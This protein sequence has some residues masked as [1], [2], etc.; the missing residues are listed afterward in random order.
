[1]GFG[2]ILHNVEH[3]VHEGLEITSHI[4]GAV[5]N[6]STT[7]LDAGNAIHDFHNHNII[8]GMFETGEAIFHGVE[9][10][11]DVVSGDYL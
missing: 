2:R 5:G 8:G 11:G 4:G 7:I 1:M 9:T 3:V 10:Y 6:A